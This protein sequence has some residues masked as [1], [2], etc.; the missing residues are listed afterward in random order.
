[1]GLARL[2]KVRWHAST[3]LLAAAVAVSLAACGGSSSSTTTS[4]SSSSPGSSSQSSTSTSSSS[5]D[6][7]ASASSGQ[8]IF[9][10][11]GCADCHT[12]AAAHASG[13]I[14]PDLDELKP[15]YAKVVG[16]VTNGGANMPS[17]AGRLSKAQIDAVAKF[18]ASATR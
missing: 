3:A 16:Q 5:S 10:S 15:P 8:R 7:S 13:S 14:G 18:V 11:A 2:Q 6:S 12:L 4:Q 1:M 9:T 17:F